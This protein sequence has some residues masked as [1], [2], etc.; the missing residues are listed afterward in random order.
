MLG[1]ELIVFILE[2]GLENVDIFDAKFFKAFPTVGDVAVEFNVGTATVEAWIQTERLNAI[3]FDGVV[4]ISPVSV[5][6][7]AE[8]YGKQ[9]VK[10]V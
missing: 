10:N 6:K 8:E 5:R 1:R 2:N 9:E 3:E 4:Y 7:L